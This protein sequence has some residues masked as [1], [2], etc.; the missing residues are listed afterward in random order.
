MSASGIKL[1]LKVRVL[2]ALGIALVVFHTAFLIP[3]GYSMLSLRSALD[4]VQSGQISQARE[5][6]KKNSQIY[7]AR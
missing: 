6:V 3:L 1:S 7:A 4:S 2:L 5:R